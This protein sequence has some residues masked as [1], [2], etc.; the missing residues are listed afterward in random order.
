MCAHLYVAVVAHERLRI[1]GLLASIPILPISTLVTGGF[2]GFGINWSLSV[3]SFLF[4]IVRRRRWFFL[5]APFVAYAGLSLFVTYMGERTGIRDVVWNEQSGFGDRFG[6]IATIV[7][8]FQFLDL[9]DT[10]HLD[11]IDGRLN[12]NFLVGVVV[13]RLQDEDL[14]LAYGGTVSLWALIPR[15]IWPDKPGVGGGGTLVSELT[16]LAFGEGTSVGAGQVLEFYANFGW[17]GILVGFSALGALLMH[18]DRGI[19][20]AFSAGDQRGLI[21][22][23]LPGLVLLQPG[24]N[25]L[26]ILV[27]V[28]GAIATAHLVAIVERR[29]SLRERLSVQRA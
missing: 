17:I 4:V 27:S 23:A 1:F 7:T 25:L 13:R 3:I 18:L 20:R 6:R 15:A 24:G 2:V 9:E 5:L 10:A 28:V 21:L 22:R 19:M 26:E 16:G 8:N 12:Q 29:R 11:A 14:E